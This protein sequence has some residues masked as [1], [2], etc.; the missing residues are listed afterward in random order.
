MIGSASYCLLASRH[1][2]SVL[3]HD[4]SILAGAQSRLDGSPETGAGTWVFATA[5]SPFRFVRRA[6]DS[7]RP[8]RTPCRVF[9]PRLSRPPLRGGYRC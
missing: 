2:E 5:Q 8:W 4:E 1:G 7:P 6:S 9:V 3:K